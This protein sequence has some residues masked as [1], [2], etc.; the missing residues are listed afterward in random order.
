MALLDSQ[1][2]LGSVAG[3]ASEAGCEM[4]QGESLTTNSPG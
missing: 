1:G 3:H 4:K 2:E